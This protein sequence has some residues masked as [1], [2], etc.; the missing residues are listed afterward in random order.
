MKRRWPPKNAPLLARVAPGTSS[1]PSASPK[2]TASPS[3]G[4]PSKRHRAAAESALRAPFASF[5]G[6][7]AYPTLTERAAVLLQHLAKNHP[8]PDA[9]MRAAFLLTAR[10][11]DANCL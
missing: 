2:S 1:S 5:G 7:E 9:N 6:V 8:L 11:L 3:T 10:L 4:S